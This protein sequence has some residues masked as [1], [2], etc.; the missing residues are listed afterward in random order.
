MKSKYDPRTVKHVIQEYLILLADYISLAL[1]A[2]LAF[3][4]T[5]ILLALVPCRLFFQ[6]LS[7]LF[8]HAV[9]LAFGLGQLL[10]QVVGL[11]LAIG[12]SLGF[13]YGVV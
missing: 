11:G 13:G 4:L 2:I 9:S 10:I 8:S 6:Y 1:T 7:S 3:Y 5:R 12:V